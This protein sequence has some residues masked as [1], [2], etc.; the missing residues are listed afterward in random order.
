MAIIYIA[1][2]SF[3]IY[4]K[5]QLTVLNTRKID[6]VPLNHRKTVVCDLIISFIV[7]RGHEFDFHNDF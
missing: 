7:V 5:V 1:T 2:T 6:E 4:R 3:E